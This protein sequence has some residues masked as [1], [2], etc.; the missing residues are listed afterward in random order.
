MPTSDA[1]QPSGEDPGAWPFV[2]WPGIDPD[3]LDRLAPIGGR[4][5]WR[6]PRQVGAGGEEE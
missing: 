1:P 2:K 4:L 6:S 5:P 3:H